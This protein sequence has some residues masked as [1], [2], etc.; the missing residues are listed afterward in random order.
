[1]SQIGRGSLN[2]K[3]AIGEMNFNSAADIA[4]VTSVVNLPILAFSM[5]FL[6]LKNG[7]KYFGIQYRS[8]W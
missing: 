6:M 1:M 7:G 8:H 4:T 5:N 3:L 2:F